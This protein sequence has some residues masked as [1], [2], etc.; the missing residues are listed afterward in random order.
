MLQVVNLIKEL[1]AAA[2]AEKGIEFDSGIE[3]RLCA[4]ARSVAHFPT[5]VK[6]V[7]SCCT[8]V[9]S[10]ISLNMW[11]EL[12]SFICVGHMEND[13]RTGQESWVC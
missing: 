3:G 4:Y 8:W 2:A 1:A 5:A 12:S 7:N 6:E 10:E 11:S 13:Q 9:S